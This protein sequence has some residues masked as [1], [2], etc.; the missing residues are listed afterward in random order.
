MQPT[1]P[2]WPIGGQLATQLVYESSQIGQDNARAR[3]VL[4]VM[5]LDVKN[6]A[7]T[8]VV[9]ITSLTKSLSIFCRNIFVYLQT[10]THCASSATGKPF[11][12]WSSSY[13]ISEVM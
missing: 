4:R 7:L 1:R 6:K 2:G 9:R 10:G 5:S 11:P 3:A 13:E 8:K 12:S